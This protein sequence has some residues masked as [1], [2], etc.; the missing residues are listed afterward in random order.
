MR[1]GLKFRRQLV[2]GENARSIPGTERPTGLLALPA[3][4]P[5]CFAEGFYF[6]LVQCERLKPVVAP[7]FLSTVRTVRS[8]VP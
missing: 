6:F 5:F 8:P 4:A 1:A 2:V 3:K 7:F